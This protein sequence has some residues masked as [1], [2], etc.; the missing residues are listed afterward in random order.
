MVADFMLRAGS[1]RRGDGRHPW[2][3]RD[4][5]EEGVASSGSVVRV[6][7]H[8]K[9]QI[10]F[11]AYSAESK[12]A[13]RFLEFGSHV[14][15]PTLESLEQ[16]FFAVARRRAPLVEY[17]DAMRLVS[18][19]ADGLPGVIVDRYGDVVVVQTSTPFAESLLE[20][21][22]RW[23]ASLEG[24]AAVFAR[25]DISVR[26]LENLPQECRWL[27]GTPRDQ[28]VIREGDVE[29]E[30]DLVGGQKTGFFLDQRE[31]RRAVAARVREGAS[32]LDAFAYSGGFAL[33][34]ARAGGNVTAYDDSKGAIEILKRNAA[35][36]GL[37]NVVAERGNSFELLR[38]L[39]KDGKT[40]DVVVL[41]PPAFAKN[42]AEREDALRGYRE[43]NVRA[44]KLVNPGG[45]VVSASCSYQIDEPAFERMLRDA[46]SDAG[47]TALV[48][49]RGE[50]DVDHPVLLALPESRYLKCW[51]L[52]AL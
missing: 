24:V 14:T 33:H 46:A 11:A 28:V 35:R 32:V 5:V 7:D 38:Q 19:E 4:Q 8:E 27:H 31:N 44:F 20:D 15:M 42:K 26:R 40:F 37:E 45:L 48:E 1:R 49:H 30:V 52:R 41:D 9:R 22:G 16:R 12:I 51:F 39:A 2:I 47:R 23:A 17:T 13:L 21:L 3:Y 18:S 50:Q 43:I 36:N 6:V 34:A 25:N 10:G 29:F